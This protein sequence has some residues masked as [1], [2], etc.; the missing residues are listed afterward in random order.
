MPSSDAADW[1]V[2]RSRVWQEENQGDEH[3]KPSIPKIVELDI[4]RH[5]QPETLLGE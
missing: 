3:P 5:R 1:D 4:T 2:R